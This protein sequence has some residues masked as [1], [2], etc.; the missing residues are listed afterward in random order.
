[1][2]A[3]H[4]QS[5]S[6]TPHIARGTRRVPHKTVTGRHKL[7]RFGDALL[8]H[9]PNKY[10]G[11]RG[12]QSTTFGRNGISSCLTENKNDQ[13]GTFASPSDT[14]ESE[15]S[16]SDVGPGSLDPAHQ[17]PDGPGVQIKSEAEA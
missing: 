4:E 2:E 10:S 8:S 3:V 14:V 5:V 16:K 15:A 9:G 13:L 11:Q 17:A 1:M 6:V 12:H 7:W